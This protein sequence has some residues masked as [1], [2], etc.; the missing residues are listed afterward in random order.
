MFIYAFITI[1]F[2]FNLS[3]AY[4]TCHKSYVFCYYLKDFEHFCKEDLHIPESSDTVSNLETNN[5]NEKFSKIMEL[6]GLYRPRSALARALYE[7][8]RNDGH[9]RDF[10]KHEVTIII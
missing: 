3:N 1:L 10:D 7:K 8:Q 5:I 4:Y 6:N 9:L 2:L